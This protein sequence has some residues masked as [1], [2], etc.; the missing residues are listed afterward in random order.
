MLNWTT[1]PLLRTELI[2][3]VAQVCERGKGTG[4]EQKSQCV[5]GSRRDSTQWTGVETCLVLW[6]YRQLELGVGQETIYNSLK[7]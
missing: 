1:P 7:S 3:S 4:K 6:T 5:F 2:D